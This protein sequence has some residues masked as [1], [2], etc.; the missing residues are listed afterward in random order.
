M[1]VNSQKK[2][3]HRPSDRK[4]P[5][6]FYCDRLIF[7]SLLVLATLYPLVVNP[8]YAPIFTMFKLLILRLIT[9]VMISA[10]LVKAVKKGT[11]TFTSHPLNFSILAFIGIAALSTIF[12]INPLVSFFGEYARW[13]GLLTLINYGL[14]YLVAQSW[15]AEP[16]EIRYLAFGLAAG[17][18]IVSALGLAEHFIANPV[19]RYATTTC[20][21]GFGALAPGSATVR[22]FSTF[23]NAA[24][25]GGYL[26][27]VFPVTLSLLLLSKHTWKTL[28][29]LLPVNAA[30][31]GCW[32]FTLARAAWLGVFA[33]IL[34]IIFLSWPKLRP[35]R[36]LLLYA[37]VAM[38]IVILAV[39]LVPTRTKM[40]ARDL[41]GR[42]ASIV[43][44]SSGSGAGNRLE[45]WKHTLP[46][47]AEH[48]L[49]GTGP[50]TYKIAFTK[51][52]PSY[53]NISYKHPQLDKAHNELFQLGVTLGVLGAISFVWIVLLYL[54]TAWSRLA[55]SKE[56]EFKPLAIG[57]AAGVLGYFVNLQFVFSHLSVSPLFWLF[58][59]LTPVIFRIAGTRYQ[60][61][62]FRLS[63][64][65]P[66]K[67]LLE[68]AII[69]IAVLLAIGSIRLWQA[70]VSF[71]QANSFQVRRDW[72]L[73]LKTYEKAAA[74]NPFSPDYQLYLGKAYGQAALA[75][76][77]ESGFSRYFNR[78][79]QVFKKAEAL[80]PLNENTY[81]V[82]GN[83][84]LGAGRLQNDQSY[85]L[86][87][88]PLFQKGLELNPFSS[89]ALLD[90]GA[91]YG[92]LQQFNEAI[93]A[94]NKVVSIDASNADAYYNLGWAYQ[95]LKDF[96]KAKP[97]F[98]KALDLHRGCQIKNC[99]VCQDSKNALKMIEQL[100]KQ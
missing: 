59:G 12:S 58:L 60:E 93:K 95:N 23:G 92:N 65:S 32:L 75:A 45:M 13:E 87:A 71:N 61:T 36:P 40:N 35:G 84:Y 26:T 14:I 97:Y 91:A 57:L 70:D 52:K 56:S 76:T 48:P 68:L 86:Q 7:G 80:N 5:T 67:E 81:F 82:Q 51:Y 33:G 55:K 29:F 11:F 3:N 28:F 38:M 50:D 98:R 78:S 94:W 8:F 20:G 15:A 62:S 72:P 49:L 64:N 43:D 73:L 85:V 41:I 96:E 2:I 53:W 31:F 90:L 42:F 27:L 63:L 66:S 44:F 100:E 6:C 88:V 89:D 69:V 54:W 24:F 25:L 4:G 74:L 9:L 47:I 39:L 10:W 21:G 30:V 99:S 83:I 18:L 46:I 79:A 77:G 37:V 22:S 17:A 1:K 19:L 16:R 34:L